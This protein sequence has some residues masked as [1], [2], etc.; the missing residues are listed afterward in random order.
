MRTNKLK[1]TLLIIFNVIFLLVISFCFHFALLNP[2]NK[3]L[4]KGFIFFLFL[5]LCLGFLFL[6]FITKNLSKRSLLIISIINLI[7]FI[8][9]QI[10]FGYFFSVNPSWDMIS[11]FNSATKVASNEWEFFSSY[12]Y[13]MYP[14]NIFITVLWMKFYKL[15]YYFSFNLIVSS[16]IINIIVVLISVIITYIL[17]KKVFNIRVA[18]ISSF[19]FIVITPFY[20]YTPI[21]YTDTLTMIFL[22]LA[23]LLFYIYIKS[24]NNF[25]SLSIFSIFIIDNLKG[26]FRFISLFLISFIVSS[27]LINSTCQ[28]YI[29][30]PLKDA[31]LP[32]THWIMMG[33][34]DNGGFN[35]EDVDLS[36]K[37]GKTRKEIQE[38]NIKTI[39][40]RLKNY[41]IDGYSK[42]LYKKIQYTWGDGT[43]FAPV[44]LSRKPIRPNFLH[45]YIYGDK[46]SLFTSFS[47]ASHSLLLFL[48]LIGSIGLF[49]SKNKIGFLFNICI[50]G[51]FLF[52]ILWEARSRYLVCILPILVCSS[53]IGINE[54]LKLKP[55]L[56]KKRRL[57]AK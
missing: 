34:K 54:I 24:K 5:L 41:G 13:K 4:N 35:K 40:T 31:G 22:P 52:L 20:S 19:L 6:F 50:F 38:F 3:N 33:L 7:I 21:F 15:C 18:T 56:N 47:E 44:K 11:I 14:N 25:I 12:F 2:F 42:F 29:P 26:F 57:E 53:S 1:N 30:V 32:S 17:I 49:K 37:A 9:L 45:T 39:K 36:K 48:I 46:N 51:V 8:L 23:F 10:F 28:K 27:I 55:F 43:Y 16:V